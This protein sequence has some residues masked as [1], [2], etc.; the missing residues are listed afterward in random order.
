ME[1]K[2]PPETFFL[3]RQELN[4]EK[5]STKISL[6]DLEKLTGCTYKTLVKRL[7]DLSPVEKASKALYYDSREAL[8]LIYQ[9]NNS[10]TLDLTKEKARLA[11]VQ[12]DKIEFELEK[13]KGKSVDIEEWGEEWA[14]MISAFKT[15]LRNMANKIAG[16]VTLCNN[17]EENYALIKEAVD[18]ALDELVAYEPSNDQG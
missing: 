5:I 9:S 11:K 14:R 1:G 18:E 2:T 16:A 13:L 15:N 7:K 4:H 12:A 3:S 8:P 10:G 6:A 17:R